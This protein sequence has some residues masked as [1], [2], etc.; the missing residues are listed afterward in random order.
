[1]FEV[2]QKFE[3]EGL[4]NMVVR[5]AR[6]MEIKRETG[7]FKNIITN[8]GLE[9]LATKGG[10][11]GC[12]VGTGN[13]TPLVTDTI[14]QAQI[15]RTTTAIGT[16]TYPSSAVSP[17]YSAIR[18]TYRFQ[19]GAAAG[20]LSEV[21]ILHT[22][23]GAST[24]ATLFSRSLIKDSSGNPTTITVLSNEIL[25]VVYE[26]RTYALETDI[27]VPGIIIL[28]NS[29][30]FTIRTAEAAAG[31]YYNVPDGGM[32]SGLRMGL[33]A[34]TGTIGP[35]TGNTAGTL[36]GSADWG[37]TAAYVANSYTRKWAITFSLT[38]GNGTHAS[39]RTSFD[40]SQRPVYQMAISPAF[41]KNNTMALTF[42]MSFSW[43][44]KT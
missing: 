39:Y 15:A 20:N 3:L 8:S 18:R 27:V 12:A 2:E 40:S 21:G 13:N 6:T 11:N 14:L 26:C 1:M 31:N 17:Y 44:R 43:S 19:E 10:I 4:F 25:D 36:I 16:T 38:Q 9:I 30:T 7:F 33:S 34:Y 35:I 5:D 23:N 28:G 32:S 24:P 22:D 42:N 37:V 41:V 29:Y